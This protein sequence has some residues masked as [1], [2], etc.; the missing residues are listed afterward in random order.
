MAVAT[1]CNTGSS[2]TFSSGDVLF[3]SNDGINFAEAFNM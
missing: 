1:R 3:I 2:G